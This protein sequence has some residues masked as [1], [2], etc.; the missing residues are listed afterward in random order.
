M[1]KPELNDCEFSIEFERDDEDILEDPL[2]NK[3]FIFVNWFT[4]IRDKNNIWEWCSLKVICKF[5]L[6]E[7]DG[8][9]AWASFVNE[10]AFKD[11]KLYQ[12]LKQTAYDE[13]LIIMERNNDG[14]S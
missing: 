8:V 7:G 13:M 6:F 12:D 5:G 4:K 2:F 1:Y 9:W 3:D 11:S 14:K 10:N